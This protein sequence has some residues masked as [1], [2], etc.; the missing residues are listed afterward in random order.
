MNARATGGRH[1]LA[2]A[3]GRPPCMRRL[4]GATEALARSVAGA[5]SALPPGPR[6]PPPPPVDG[7]MLVR[8]AV[9]GG[10]LHGDSVEPFR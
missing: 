1:P 7:W 6:P 2:A 4:E 8:G 10:A 5:W 9:D 3:A